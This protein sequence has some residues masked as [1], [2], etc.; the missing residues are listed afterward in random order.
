MVKPSSRAW[1]IHAAAL[2]SSTIWLSVISSFICPSG[3]PAA[4][5]VLR[6]SSRKCWSATWR[7]AKLMPMNRGGSS[8]PRTLRSITG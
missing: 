4:W 8:G 5:Q 7:A 3:K 1:A 6:A 2:V